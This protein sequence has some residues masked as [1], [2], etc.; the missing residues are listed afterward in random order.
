MAVGGK[1]GLT[2]G[3]GL[4]GDFGD[5]GFG[6]T[7]VGNGGD[8]IASTVQDIV[9]QIEPGFW[10]CHSVG[11]EVVGIGGKVV[12]PEVVGDLT[13]QVFSWKQDAFL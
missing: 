2:D 4:G 10:Q 7:R 11:T 8:H 6:R 9:R 1:G 3:V 5:G 12:G 13:E